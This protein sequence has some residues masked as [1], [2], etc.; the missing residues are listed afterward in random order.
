MA[1]ASH[2]E[3]QLDV[4]RAGLRRLAN[5]S[6]DVLARAARKLLRQLHEVA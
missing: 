6:N 1:R 5:G 3:R 4:M 2:A